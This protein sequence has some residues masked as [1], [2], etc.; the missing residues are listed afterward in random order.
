MEEL[1]VKLIESEH[2]DI[3]SQEELIERRERH[4]DDLACIGL[5]FI[6]VFIHIISQV[7]QN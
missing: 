5:M 1:K 3:E 6:F 7:F 4:K 2:Y